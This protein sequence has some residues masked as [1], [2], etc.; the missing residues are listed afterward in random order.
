MS[1]THVVCIADAGVFAD[2][3][4]FTN[5]DSGHRDYVRAARDHH[6]IAQVDASISL[7]LQ[8]HSRVEKHIL[9]DANVPTSV[10]PGTP[11]NNDGGGQYFIYGRSKRG[12]GIDAGQVFP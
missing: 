2:E 9:A 7:S 12:M 11:Q 5:V 3:C 1:I 4:T 8:V 6:F 10:D